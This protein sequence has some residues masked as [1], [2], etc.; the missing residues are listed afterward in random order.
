MPALSEGT[1]FIFAILAPGFLFVFAFYSLGRLTRDD[2]QYGLV[3]DIGAVVSASLL[4]H[5]IFGLL[6]FSLINLLYSCV[7]GY[8]F[9]SL[10]ADL[11]S[12]SFFALADENPGFVFLILLYP[13]TVCVL[14]FSV[15]GLLIRE[16]ERGRWSVFRLIGS[17]V[18]HGP[19]YDAIGFGRNEPL[20]YINVSVLTNINFSGKSVIYEGKAIDVVLGQNNRISSVVIESP[21]RRLIKMK[22]DSFEVVDEKYLT[23]VHPNDTT[24]GHIFIGSENIVN[25]VVIKSVVQFAGAKPRL[26]SH[27]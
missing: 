7:N 6:Y 4:F 24:I 23:T 1:L 14:S 9:W 20:R 3:F 2:Y 17:Q 18:T 25:V 27:S 12:S 11:R 19:I 21:Y 22:D 13:V 16:I 5:L 15:G 26:M 8:S 10:A